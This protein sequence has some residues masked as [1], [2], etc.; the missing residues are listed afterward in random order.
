MIQQ[1]TFFFGAD[2]D[3]E[4]ALTDAENQAN[5]FLAGMPADRIISVKNYSML[6]PSTPNNEAIEDWYRHCIAIVYLKKE[7]E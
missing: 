1:T 3:F 2:T 7:N 4:L 5:E 6:E